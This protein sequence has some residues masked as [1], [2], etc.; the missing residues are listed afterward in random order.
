VK[1][2]EALVMAVEPIAACGNPTKA[3]RMLGW[4]NTVPFTEMVA[5]LVDSELE[6]LK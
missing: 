3:R 1:H 4:E 5:R 2:D 6:K